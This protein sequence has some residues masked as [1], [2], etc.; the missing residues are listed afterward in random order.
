M[1]LSGAAARTG[2]FKD[3][4]KGKR[5]IMGKVGR[6]LSINVKLCERTGYLIIYIDNGHWYN[7]RNDTLEFLKVVYR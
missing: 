1:R 2:S 3:K 5:A 4:E 7:R 6:R